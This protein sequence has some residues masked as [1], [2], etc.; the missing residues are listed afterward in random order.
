MKKIKIGLSLAVGITA[1][2]V[3]VGP[4]GAMFPSGLEHNPNFEY[5]Q[6][7]I[8]VKFKGDLKPFRVVK[9]PKGKVFEEMGK[10]KKRTD[11]LYAEPNYIAHTMMVP[12]DP[13][14][15]LQWHLDNS[16]Y[17]GIHTEEAWDIS[18]GSGVTVA[19][20]DTGITRGTD[21]ADTC[22]VAGYDFVN[23]DAFPTDDNGH[24]THVAGTV[25]QSTNNGIG[26]AGVAYGAC[27]M[28]VKVLGSTG[29]G[30]YADVAD[31]IYFAANNGAQVIN[32][33]LG[34]SA[35]SDTLEAAVTHA[36]ANGVTVVAAAGNDSS[37][38]ISYPAAYDAYVIAV[39]ATRYDETLAY[40][41]N[42]GP[43]LDLVAPGGDVTVDQNGDGYGDGVLQQ[44]F[45]RTGRSGRVTWGYYFFQ[46]T[47]MA[48]PH[49][50]GVAAL[51]IANGNAITPNDVR[52]VLQETAEDLGPAGFDAIYGHGLIDA[53]SALGYAAVPVDNPP[54][55]SVTS[56]VDGVTVSGTI[57]ITADAT[58]DSGVVQVD[59]YYDS[60]L[61]GTDTDSPYSVDWKSTLV[62]DDLY[63][64]TAIATDTILQTDSDSVSVLVDNVAE[65]PTLV[66]SV[67]DIDMS[68][69]S[70]RVR[71]YIYTNAVAT[72][73]IVD[74]GGSPVEGATVS[75][76]WSG[77]TTD[78]DSGTTNAEGKIALD[79]DQIKNTDGT[80]TFTVDSVTK[81]GWTY[82][83]TA[84]VETSDS[85]TVN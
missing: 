11:V 19:V 5:A 58:D 46:G 7:E 48:A 30:T 82:N 74:G 14:Y 29:S 56:P 59:F 44:T 4:V 55:V 36:Y 75:G 28:P 71:R 68:T 49:V 60:T 70:T 25:A 6:D 42:Y 34:G 85:I 31:G 37:S 35:P 23:D 69:E 53:A 67:S 57:L 33:S 9:V 73:T 32:L 61:I 66:M 50:A 65:E 79:S 51:V 12:N 81:E 39:G 52:A 64:L 54:T 22:F 18:T 17:G 72:V 26:V 80:F 15:G 84:N 8:I 78:T 16:V 83:L 27:L 77:L 62:D 45:Q 76:H 20:V 38:V 41:S 21:L 2:A 43:G 3:L 47:S 40:Y 13:Y 1:F 10:Y 63:T 24:G